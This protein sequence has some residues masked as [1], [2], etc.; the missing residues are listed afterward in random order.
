VLLRV[1]AK[2]SEQGCFS[3]MLSRPEWRAPSR[4]RRT[5]PPYSSY[6]S[7]GFR[8]H[9][10]CP[11]PGRAQRRRCQR[12]HS[13]CLPETWTSRRRR[14]AHSVWAAPPRGSW[15]TSFRAPCCLRSALHSCLDQPQAA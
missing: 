1:I 3:S 12:P 10:R 7:S 13:R 2:S 15:V 14:C 5:R 6:Q 11:H 8:L 4:T 9:T